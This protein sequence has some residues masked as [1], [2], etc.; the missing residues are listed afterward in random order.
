MSR[1]NLLTL[2]VCLVAVISASPPL[3]AGPSAEGKPTYRVPPRIRADC[4]VDV[5]A[6]LQRWISRVPDHSILRF[7]RRGCYRVDGTLDMRDRW[8][9]E[10]RG[11]EVRFRAFT[12]GDRFR[13]HLRFIGGGDLT[14][15]NF[16]VIGTNPTGVW[17][18]DRAGQHGVMLSGVQG[19]TLDRVVVRR[20]WGDFIYVG[21]A[22]PSQG[23]FVPSRN[24]TIIRAD[25]KVNG[26]SAI[27]I[28]MAEDLVITES[29]I[30]D[31]R[32]ATFNIEPTGRTWYVHRVSIVNNVTGAGHLRWLAN[33]GAGSDIRDIY[34]AGNVTDVP[35]G[36]PIVD[37]QNP[38]IFGERGPYTI[39][40]NTFMIRGSP[41]AAFEFW[42]GV[43]G[44]TIR[45]NQVTFLANRHMT[46]VRLFDAHEVLVTGNSFS[47][48]AVVLEADAESSDYSE[49]NNFL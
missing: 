11:R 31:V 29:W 45:N 23:V 44:V 3:L 20:V 43:R 39:E 26:R 22:H 19:A 40:N 49:S 46:A 13:H 15:R 42:G 4:A 6:R 17:N 27:S 48:A 5:T 7:P 14:L 1:R 32:R 34:V 24:V 2:A 16:R 9:L 47:G 12:L 30:R 28:T 36:A 37:V 25:L 8:G 18:E 10:F 38:N 35:T 33:A 41:R 21:P